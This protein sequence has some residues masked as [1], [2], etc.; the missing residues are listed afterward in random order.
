MSPCSVRIWN[1]HLRLCK[2]SRSNTW[3]VLDWGNPMVAGLFQCIFFLQCSQAH[4]MPTALR[5][6]IETHTTV[7]MSQSS[8]HQSLK[9]SAA[10]CVRRLWPHLELQC[11][12][13]VIVSTRAGPKR[14]GGRD[15]D[16][17]NG[18]GNCLVWQRDGFSLNPI[19]VAENEKELSM[20]LLVGGFGTSYPRTMAR[21]SRC[22]L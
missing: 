18:C 16:S 1:S 11:N 3:C 2:Q 12:G 8:H 5:A 6:N 10:C 22:N 21:A 13:L 17:G 4:V 14:P 15:S 19:I 7:I 20:Q 9:I